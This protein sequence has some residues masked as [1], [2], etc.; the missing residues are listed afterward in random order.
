MNLRGIIPP[1]KGGA[2]TRALAGD[3]DPFAQLQPQ[4]NSVFEDFFSRS[5]FDP[6]GDATREFLPRVDVSETNEELRITADLPGHDEKDVE[7]TVTNNMLTVKGEKK[8]QKEAD[9]GEYYH[10]GRSYDY[11]ER[12]HRAAA[13]DR[14]RQRQGEVQESRFESDDSQEAGSAELTGKDRVDRRLT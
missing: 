8:V 3:R 12:N 1:R 7:I 10:S 13:G 11:F 6:W 9:E 5:S 2:I 4:M 14:C